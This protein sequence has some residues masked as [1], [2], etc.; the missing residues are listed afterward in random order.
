M[1]DGGEDEPED[2]GGQRCERMRALRAL[3]WVL[4]VVVVAR[5]FAYGIAKS[6]CGGLCI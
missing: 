3:G 5:H 4:V 6:Q 2:G 1:S